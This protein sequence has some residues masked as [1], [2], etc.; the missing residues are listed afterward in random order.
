MSYPVMPK[1]KIFVRGR[2]S[3][4]TIRLH[5]GTKSLKKLFIDA[6]IPASK[7]DSVPVIADESGVLG[8][9]GFGGNLDRI[10][11]DENAVRIKIEYL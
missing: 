2:Q 4:D 11:L 1:G 9:V 6:K 5:G 8:V 7:R 10:V 3:G